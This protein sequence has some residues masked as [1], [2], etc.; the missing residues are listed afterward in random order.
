[1]LI[2]YTLFFIWGAIGPNAMILLLE[3]PLLFALIQTILLIKFYPY[4]TPKYL[5]IKGD[6]EKVTS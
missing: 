4:E 6:F 3:L 2:A 1:M 5:I